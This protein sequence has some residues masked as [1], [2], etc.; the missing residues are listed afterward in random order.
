MMT[1]DELEGALARLLEGRLSGAGIVL[2][3]GWEDPCLV[4][5]PMVVPEAAHALQ[6]DPSTAFDFLACLT[7][8]DRSPAEP[9]FEVVYHLRSLG[10]RTRLVMRTRVG[11][12]APSVPSV[13]GVWA[14]AD[15]FEREA[16]DL[17]GIS[18]PG[19]PDLRR[20]LLPADWEG[21]PLRRDYP[22][23]GTA[24]Q[25]ARGGWTPPEDCRCR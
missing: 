24:P 25:P 1:R 22:L 17:L 3:K 18:F 4:V 2:E 13:T 21:Y 23:E 12:D 8:V 15:W 19:H 6:G 20:L 11:G 5:P 10:N 16:F 14:A 9:R 7:G